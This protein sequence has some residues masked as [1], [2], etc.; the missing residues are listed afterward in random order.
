MPVNGKWKSRPLC[1][2]AGVMPD[3]GRREGAGRPRGSG[4]G[5][6]VEVRSISMMPSA[7]AKLDQMRGSTSRG[8]WISAA[9]YRAY[10]RARR[11]DAKYA[12]LMSGLPLACGL[13]PGALLGRSF[14]V[15]P[16]LAAL[17]SSIG[18]M[19]GDREKQGATPPSHRIPGYQRDSVERQSSFKTRVPNTSGCIWSSR[20][21]QAWSALSPWA[22]FRSLRNK[23]SP[24]FAP[25]LTSRQ[26]HH[27]VELPTPPVHGRLARLSQA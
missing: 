20:L 25:I 27:P 5:K 22:L 16:I 26:R 18:M 17:V 8:V 14:S 24:S 6:T 9:V 2:I 13:A 23:G 15:D 21:A 3:S 4:N 12:N 10:N 11:F 7:W 19:M 1:V